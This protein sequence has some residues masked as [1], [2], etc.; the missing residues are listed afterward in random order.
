MAWMRSASVGVRPVVG[1][2]VTSPTLKIPNCTSPPRITATS[3]IFDHFHFGGYGNQLNRGT[4]AGIPGRDS[5]HWPPHRATRRAVAEFRWHLLV[6]APEYG[7]V[8]AN[9]LRVERNAQ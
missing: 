7:E 9:S 1:S 2:I 5:R 6:Q 8:P 4:R 3:G